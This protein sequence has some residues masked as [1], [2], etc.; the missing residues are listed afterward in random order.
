M[1][2]GIHPIKPTHQ[3]N[4]GGIRWITTMKINLHLQRLGWILLQGVFLP[5]VYYA[6]KYS[7]TPT[8][9]MLFALYMAL[10]WGDAV[11]TCRIFEPRDKAK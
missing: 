4:G 2:F 7:D 6:G 5:L 3:S 1:V 10:V 11:L 9:W 8:G